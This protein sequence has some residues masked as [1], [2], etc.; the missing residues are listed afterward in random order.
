MATATIPGVKRPCKNR[1]AI[2]CGK[3]DAVAA[4]VAG[5]AR[6]S[7]ETTI[8]RLRPSESASNPRN[9]AANATASMGAV[10]VRLTANSEAWN[11]LKAD[12]AKSGV[13]IPQFV[14][15]DLAKALANR[16]A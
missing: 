9:G 4:R 6:A 8:T 2:S 11:K 10:T 3:V 15:Q 16:Q 5:M 14:K 7:I 12:A 1:Q 13:K